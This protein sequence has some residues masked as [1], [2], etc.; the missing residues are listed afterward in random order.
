MGLQLTLNYHR[1]NISAFLLAPEL[2]V[3]VGPADPLFVVEAVA[4]VPVP[5]LFSALPCAAKT[6]IR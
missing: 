1:Q 4:A 3:V 2:A 6:F 5:M